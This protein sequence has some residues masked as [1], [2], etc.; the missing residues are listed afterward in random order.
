MR[1]KELPHLETFGKPYANPGLR[2]EAIW[3][4]E[5]SLGAKGLLSY[6]SSFNHP[7]AV[8]EICNSLGLSKDKVWKHLFELIKFDYVDVHNHVVKVNFEVEVE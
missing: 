1:E 4:E 6:V 3:N 2:L 8:F 7:I 5:V